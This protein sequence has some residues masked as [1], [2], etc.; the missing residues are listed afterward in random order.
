M[1]GRISIN[2]KNSQKINRIKVNY[3]KTQEKIRKF[4]YFLIFLIFLI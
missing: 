3:P 1:L 4:F 2:Q